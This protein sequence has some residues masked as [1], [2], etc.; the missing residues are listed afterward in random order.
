MEK[1]LKILMIS[2]DRKVLEKG[3]AVSVRMRGYGELVKELHIILLSDTSHGL[4]TAQLK[5]NVWVYPTN[6]SIKYLRPIDAARIGKKIIFEKKFIRGQAVITA[7]DPFECGWVGLKVKKKWR[8]PLE[9]QLHTDPFSFHFSGLLNNLRKKMVKRVLSS[10]DN[11]RVV[12]ERLGSSILGINPHAK[13]SVL[14]IYVDRKRIEEGH[15]AFDLR[16]RYGWHFTILGVSRLTK[17][18][19]LGLA[20]EV[21]ALVKKKFPITGLVIVGSGPEERSLKIKVKK[22]ELEGFVEFAGWQD[23]LASYYKTANVFIQTSLFEGYGLSLVEAGFSGLPV[24]TTPVGIAKE[25]ENGKDAYIYPHDRPDLFAAG[26]IDLIEN[27]IKREDLIIN[28]K[29]T[30]ESQLLSKDDYMAKIK[31]NWEDIA[32]QVKS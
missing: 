29:R 15:I 6:S 27:N 20:L 30:L 14:P 5:E 1:S 17:E 8:L 24:V 22:L 25:L 13:I 9:V 4:K 19:N 11:V 16:T 31:A 3:S 18:K 21:L 2:S 32:K 26:I 28:M 23:N 10:A 12:S 7:Q